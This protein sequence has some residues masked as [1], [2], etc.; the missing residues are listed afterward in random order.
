L[1]QNDRDLPVAEP[2]WLT[3]EYLTAPRRDVRFYIERGRFEQGGGF[4]NAVAENRRFRDVLK[5]KGYSVQYS[6]FTGGHEY[7]C[8]RGS[9]ADG[10]MA[11]AG[12][13]AGR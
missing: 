13:R 7:V 12:V 11:L 3:R 10:L 6:E 8:W 2:G 5:A 4:I 9:F 1:E